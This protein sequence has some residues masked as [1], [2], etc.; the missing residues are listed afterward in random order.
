M[1]NK[2]IL[3]MDELNKKKEKIQNMIYEMG[4]FLNTYEREFKYEE[5][6]K[7]LEKIN[8]YLN[9]K[10]E[11]IK[12]I[13]EEIKNISEELGKNC[14]HKIHLNYLLIHECPICKK[15]Y[16]YNNVPENAEYEISD[17]DYKNEAK[18]VDKIVLDSKSE[19]EANEKILSYF[20][21]LQYSRGVKI[22]RIKK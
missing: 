11:E 14:S 15:R 4:R 17:F 9:N 5:S 20:S 16:E 3:K 19:E 13:D 18:N 10:R 2:E 21:D 12:R 6:K 1:N 7:A 22:R 8:L